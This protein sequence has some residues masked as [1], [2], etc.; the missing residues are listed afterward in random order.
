[1]AH[2]VRLLIQFFELKISAKDYRKI[3]SSWPLSCLQNL[4]D[5]DKLR[6]REPPDWVTVELTRSIKCAN[7]NLN[8][9]SSSAGS[10]A[11][12]IAT[13]VEHPRH[14][15]VVVA[16][17]RLVVRI[18]SYICSQIPFAVL[19]KKSYTS[20]HGGEVDLAEGITSRTNSLKS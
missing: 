18:S 14:H 13:L 8:L 15:S 16:K 6:L 5:R 9:T 2:V 17:L 4:S 20:S 19:W 7:L 11:E 1:M 12:H 10:S 3:N